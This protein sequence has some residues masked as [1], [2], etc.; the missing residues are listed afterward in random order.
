[1]TRRTRSAAHSGTSRRICWPP[2]GT[3]DGETDQLVYYVEAGWCWQWPGWEWVAA[4]LN[5]E[6]GNNRTPQACRAKYGRIMRESNDSLHRTKMAG[7]SA[8][9]S[10]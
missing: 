6:Y 4:S 9:D 7:D 10:P 3:I 5:D 2:L 8:E 1:M